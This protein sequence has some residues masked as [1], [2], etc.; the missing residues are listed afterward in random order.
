MGDKKRL[1]CRRYGCK[2]L[3]LLL[4]Y[5]TMFSF[6]TGCSP[7]AT[8]PAESG[9]TDP[10]PTDA[11]LKNTIVE[12]TIQKDQ[13]MTIGNHSQTG[14]Q[15]QIPAGAFSD[16]ANLTMTIL[17]EN[18]DSYRTGSFEMIGSPVE[19]KISGKENLRLG[20]PVPVTVQ[21][22]TPLLH[23][24]AAEELFFAYFYDDRWEYCMP[25]HFDLQEG[26]A[27][28]NA[29]HFSIFGFGKPSESD[30]IETY[31][32]NYAALQWEVEQRNKKLTDS[33]SR[34]YDDLFSSMGITDSAVRNQ[35]AADVISYLESAIIDSEGMAPI[36]ALAQMASAAGKGPEGKQDFQNKLLEFTGKGLALCLDKIQNTP[37][38]QMEKFTSDVNILGNLASALGSWSG[39]D[40][41]AAAQS[42][43]NMLKGLNPVGGLVDSTLSF[44]KES[45]DSVI[46]YWTQGEI[47][48]AYQ[49]YTGGGAGKYGYESGLEGDLQSI[50]IT[51]GGGERMMNIKIVKKYCEKYGINESE[52]T[53]AER[54]RIIANAMTVLKRN[55]DTRVV[56]DAEISRRKQSEEAFIAQLK[57]EGLLSASNYQQFFGIDKNLRNYNV[58][59]RLARLYKIRATVLSVMDEETAVTIS[60]EFL[61]KAIAQWVYWNEKGDRTGF[62]KYMVEMGYLKNPI[63]GLAATADEQTPETETVTETAKADGSSAAQTEASKP[64]TPAPPPAQVPAQAWVL[65]GTRVNDWQTRLSTN[66]AANTSWRTDISASGNSVTF[67]NTY[68]GS[69]TDSWMRNGMSETGTV[70]W[71]SPPETILPDQTV[72]VKL[73]AVNGPRDHDNFD[74]IASVKVGLQRLDKDGKITGNLSDWLDASGAYLVGYISGRGK[75]TQSEVAATMTGK[76]GTGSTDGQRISVLVRAQGNGISVDT[77]Y[78]YEWK[79]D[80]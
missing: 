10:A 24:I 62:Y 18:A 2:M 3:S 31:A 49:V 6:L 71:T 51:L 33:L 15:L 48:K 26:T 76:L 36:E 43:A 1:F 23:D 66:N 32:H 73:T 47:E 74:G 7:S 45:A 55:F 28:F 29:Y 57:A 64:D 9:S 63:P 44:I 79:Q 58:G 12:A 42:I 56:A 27:T 37:G 59:D 11:D 54:D 75:V 5:S 72:S 78:I 40:N 60:D 68:I 80:N 67:T 21:M 20:E 25:D 61:A 8:N 41:E 50:F 17:T 77:E 30:Q 52:L 14:W 19:I 53:L 46:D 35:L 22:P 65:T 38:E 4:I 13:D 34:Q 39:G 69:R 16:E 70:T